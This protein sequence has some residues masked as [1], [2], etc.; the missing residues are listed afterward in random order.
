[1]RVPVIKQPML[2]T[3]VDKPFDD[4][5]WLFELKW[6]GFRAIC[7]TGARGSHEL[8]SR[9]GLSLNKKFPELDGLAKESTRSPLVRDGEIVSLDE[10]GRSSFQRLQRRFKPGSGAKDDGT[11]VYAV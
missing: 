3:L 1:M 9:N 10:R 7:T 11:I 8:V 6:D 4:D 5:E 2:P